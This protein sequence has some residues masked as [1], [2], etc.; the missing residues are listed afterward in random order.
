MDQSEFDRCLIELMGQHNY[1]VGRIWGLDEMGTFAGV[2]VQVSD[3]VGVED[4][5][6]SESGAYDVTEL[7]VRAD[8]INFLSF[9]VP[10]TFELL[11]YTESDTHPPPE[12]FMF[13]D[14]YEVG[15][16]GFSPLMTAEDARYGGF[17][18][19][20]GGITGPGVEFLYGKHESLDEA[21]M[22]DE[23]SLGIPVVRDALS[24]HLP[25][26][27]LEALFTFGLKNRSKSDRE[28]TRMRCL[29]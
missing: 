12:G 9:P 21:S 23:W 14:L 13:C 5:L 24:P 1:G 2:G 26:E 19:L 8:D 28:L 20:A 27:A 15:P 29:K 3:A 18:S 16:D 7:P 6:D 25:R 10:E 4:E 11:P 17:T 22:M